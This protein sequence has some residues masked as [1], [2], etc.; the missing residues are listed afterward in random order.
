MRNALVL[1]RRFHRSVL[2]SVIAK[3]T[4]LRKFT[5]GSTDLQSAGGNGKPNTWQGLGAAEFDLR[6]KYNRNHTVKGTNVFDQAT[7]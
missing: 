3:P 2:G 7:Q 1:G 5:M 6:S 4:H